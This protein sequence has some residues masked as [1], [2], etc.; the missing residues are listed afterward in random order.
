MLQVHWDPNFYSSLGQNLRTSSYI[1]ENFFAVLVILSGL[2]F[3]LYLIGNMQ[4]CIIYTSGIKLIIIYLNVIYKNYVSCWQIYLQSRTAKAEEMRLKGKEI[5]QWKGF[6][7]LSDNLQQK[8]RKYRQ[9]VWRETRGVD[10]ENLIR[11]L[12][13][14]LRSRVK[15]ELSLDLLKKVS[16]FILNKYLFGSS[17]Y[18]PSKANCSDITLRWEWIQIKLVKL[19]C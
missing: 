11:N 14:D 16:V 2:M 7:K 18:P 4:V 8:V 17:G 3:F 10:V 5:E 9:Y 6:R 1:W 15:S 13:R 12:P 19:N